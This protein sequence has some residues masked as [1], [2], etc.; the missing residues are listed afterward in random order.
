VLIVMERP[1]QDENRQ[2]RVACG[3]T[4]QELDELYLPL[5]GLD[6][7]QVRVCNTVLCGHA[8]NKAPDDKTIAACARHH[9]AE[10]IARTQPE[11]IVLCGSSACSLV[12]GI[13]LELHHG[14]P[15]HTGKVGTLFGWEGWLV[16]M[17]H[18]AIGLH[19]SRWMQVCMDDWQGL[20]GTLDMH[21]R[22]YEAFIGGPAPEPVDYKLITDTEGLRGME[23][24]SVLAID[25]ES[26]A[27][28]PWSV[29]VSWQ[30]RQGVLIRA[31]DKRTLRHL[32][33][34]LSLYRTIFHNA[35]YDMEVLHKL[36]CDILPSGDTMQEAF[37]LGNLPQG[38]K[39]LVYRLFRH[40]MTSYQETVWPASIRALQDWMLEAY[41]V[42]VLDLQWRSSRFHKKTGKPLADEV[43]KSDLESLL[44]RLLDNT[45]PDGEYNPWGANDE[46][47]LNAFW[48]DPL[49]E[50]MVSHVEARCGG[51]PVP[52]IANCTMEEAV[53]YAVGDADWTGRVAV[54][55]ARRRGDAFRIH[56]GDRDEFHA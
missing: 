23:N 39:P 49:N 47:R 7:S 48:Q 56:E 18:P 6:R 51:Y 41:R 27:G 2:G 25:T 42:A 3:K 32:F 34:G 54:E 38:L 14:I 4:G 13:R 45:A 35:S 46:P 52:G 30:P 9:V 37:H 10:E 26:H 1:G 31:V 43:R 19:E 50:W 33:A 17:Y 29:Q 11:V 55:L 20:S 21:R 8:A 44:K 24:A 28:H 16:P 15:Q 12:P 40:T 36:G 5:A 53:N 22:G